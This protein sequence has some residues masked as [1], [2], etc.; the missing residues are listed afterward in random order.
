MSHALIREIN[1]ANASDQWFLA[2]ENSQ[3]LK[4]KRVALGFLQIWAHSYG[5]IF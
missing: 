1:V 5:S 3:P 4:D 2:K